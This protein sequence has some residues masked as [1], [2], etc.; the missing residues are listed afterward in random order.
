MS[1]KG[2]CVDAAITD[3]AAWCA[4]P[5]AICGLLGVLAVSYRMLAATVA[6]TAIQVIGAA[7]PFPLEQTPRLDSQG[8]I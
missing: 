8:S 6:F 2:S 5:Q 4:L 7:Y 1:T 3:V